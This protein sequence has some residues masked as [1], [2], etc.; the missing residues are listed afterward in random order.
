MQISIST[1]LY[2][3][4]SS[5]AVLG[6]VLFLLKDFLKKWFYTYVEEKTKQNFRI[7]L[8]DHRDKLKTLHSAHQ[9]NHLEL[10]KRR[11]DAIEAF[12]KALRSLQFEVTIHSINELETPSDIKEILKLVKKILITSGQC[13][14]YISATL[15]STLENAIDRIRVLT[16]GLEKDMKSNS[17]NIK[18][19]RSK[20]TTELN[21]AMKQ[22]VKEAQ[23][24]FF[25]ALKAERLLK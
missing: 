24:E 13:S 2:T 10:T 20:M 16:I 14:L 7:E 11:L 17:E 23:Q 19:N 5:S 3:V 6:V 1:L 12:L 15:N 25:S 9:N 22:L 18:S 8:E 21:V 4:L